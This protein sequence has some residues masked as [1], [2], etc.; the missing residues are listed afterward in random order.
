MTDLFINPSLTIAAASSVLLVSIVKPILLLPQFVIYTRIASSSIEKDARYLNLGVNKVNLIMLTGAIL[1]YTCGLLVPIFWIG[2]PISILVLVGFLFGYMNWRNAKVPEAMKFELIG[3]RLEDARQARQSKRAE[4]SVDLHFI[5]SN[6]AEHAV[7]LIDD[8]LHEI[9]K[10]L[11]VIMCPALEVGASSVNL[12]PSREGTAVVRVVDTMPTRQEIRTPESAAAIIDYLKSLAL[13]DVEDKRRIQEGSMKMVTPTGIMTVDIKVSGS[14]A[15]QRMRIELNRAARLGRGFDKLGLLDNQKEALA[16]LDEE[17]NRHGVVLIASPEGQGLS[18]T[19]YG[20]LGRHDAFITVVKS[21]EKRIDLE[22]QGVDQKLWD[23]NIDDSDYAKTVRTFLR[24]DPDVILIDDIRDEGTAELLARSGSDGPLI[25]AELRAHG[26]ADAV[27]HWV[28][29]SGNLEKAAGALK[30][31]VISR[32]LRRLC[33]ACRQPYQPDE[34]QLKRL[35]MGEVPESQ[36][37]RATGKVNVKNKIVT[38]DTCA[39]AGYTGTIGVYEV[40]PIDTPARILIAK[41]DLKGAY[42]HVRRE[43][44]LPLL[45]EAALAKVCSGETSTDELVRVLVKK[46]S[47]PVEQRKPAEASS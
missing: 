47:A 43:E 4:K 22:L 24:R 8:P 26:I 2:W 39:G 6:G 44:R 25:Y 32:V 18:T 23:P 11:E 36:F 9:H 40:M 3:T 21:C 12:I 31:I 15:G 20:L 7:P 37:Y 35:G 1:A 33:P 14:S 13:L 5:D 41:N 30:A 38:C 45:Q 34:E 46:N 16:K 28:S 42:R 19:A 17:E 27:K 29:L 10:E